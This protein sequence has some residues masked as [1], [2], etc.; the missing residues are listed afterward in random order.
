MNLL[1]LVY[2]G[3]M[4]CLYEARQCYSVQNSIEKAI[5]CINQNLPE[6]DYR[7]KIILFMPSLL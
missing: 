2:E 7:D 6:S 3:C 5:T 1:Y 4:N